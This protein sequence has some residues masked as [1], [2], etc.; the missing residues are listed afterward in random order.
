MIFRARYNAVYRDISGCADPGVMVSYLQ[1]DGQRSEPVAWLGAIDRRVARHLN[2]RQV[3]LEIEGWRFNELDRTIWLGVGQYVV[4][5]LVE[6]GV[7]AVTDRR[8]PLL[9]STREGEDGRPDRLGRIADRRPVGFEDSEAL[10]QRSVGASPEPAPDGGAQ[11]LG[12][13]D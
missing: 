10:T 13:H 9:K 2:T 4:G 12:G 5:G 6:D 1:S 3:I 8:R 7:F 11:G